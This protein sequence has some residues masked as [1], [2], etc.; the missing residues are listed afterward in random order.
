MPGI[1]IN[2]V[3]VILSILLLISVAQDIRLAYKCIRP[4]FPQARNVMFIQN[5]DGTLSYDHR[6]SWVQDEQLPKTT[7]GYVSAAYGDSG[8]PY[9]ALRNV[10]GE[11]RHIILAVHSSTNEVPPPTVYSDLAKDQC[12]MY[13]CKI[14]KEVIDWIKQNFFI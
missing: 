8:A 3:L 12:R 5:P 9:W 11:E 1:S 14:S 13:A 10:D 2:L 6:L 4:T 7:T